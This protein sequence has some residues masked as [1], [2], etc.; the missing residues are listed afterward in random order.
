MRIIIEKTTQRGKELFLA[1]LDLQ[2]AFDTVPHETIWI[3]QEKKHVPPRLTEAIKSTFSN[4][5]GIVR[6]N[7]KESETF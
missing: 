3:A 5:T 7:G 1:F 6:T 2:A 4:I